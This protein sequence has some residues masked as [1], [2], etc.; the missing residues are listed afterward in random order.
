[1]HGL[2]RVLIVGRQEDHD[3]Q[4]A[5]SLRVHGFEVTLGDLTQ[6]AAELAGNRRPDVVL[7]NMLSAEARAN[8]RAFHALAETLKK[9]ALSSHLRIMLVGGRG[10]AQLKGAVAHVDDLLVG[11]INPL[12]VCHRLRALVRLNTM[13]EELVRRLGTSAKY[14]LD[15]PPQIAPPDD[16]GNATILVL[17]HSAGFP[18]IEAALAKRATLVGASGPDTAH[19]YLARRSFDAVLVD[20]GGNVGPCLDFAREIRRDSRQYNLPVVV[21]A[22]PEVME[23]AE[24][25]FDAGVTDAVVKPF[26]PE[27]LGIRVDALVRECRFRDCLKHIYAQARHF[28]TSDALTGLYTRGFLLEHLASVIADAKRTS[29]GFSVA[30]VSIANMAEINAM[31]GYAGGD[32]L[33]RQ[34]GE[35]IGMLIRGEDLAC[36]YSGRKFA[37]LLPDTPAEGAARAVHRITGVI[38]HTEFAV[39]GHHH[40]I[41]V[42]LTTR[43]AGFEEGD[44]TE[45]VLARAWKSDLREAA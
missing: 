2:A 5:Q 24:V 4:L 38:C 6:S 44:S 7:L 22:E 9:S 10:D 12:Q 15:A 3:R 17:G 1:M 14:G 40:P 16:T 39:E 19:D 32:R 30:G 34:V 42:A 21:L 36:R 27:E 23:G 11:E 41:A 37:V 31:L 25:L 35:T 33:I 43:I 18:A 26:S 28:A 29:Q 20:A 8:P 45:S 13:H